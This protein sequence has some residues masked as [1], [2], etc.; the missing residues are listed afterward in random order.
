MAGLWTGIALLTALAVA[1]VLLPLLRARRLAQQELAE[2]RDR[3][4][5]DIFRERLAELEQE[6]S[7]GN[8]ADGDFA[9]LKLELERGLLED[10]GDQP[11][12][13]QTA[14]VSGGQW[15]T[16]V[17]LALLVPAIAFGLYWQL[18]SA[19][20]LQLALERQA[21][22]DPFDGRTPTLEEA[23]GRLE[24]ELE[25]NPENPEGWYLLATTYMG[26]GRYSDGVAAFARVLEQLP[27]D[28]PQYAGVMGQY[29][30]ALYFANEARMSE[31]VR[32][33]VEATLALD[34]WEVTSLGLLGID[35]F[36]SQR[37]A[38]AIG[39]WAKALQQADDAAAAG[40]LRAGIRRAQQELAALGQPVPEVPGLEAAEIRVA[41]RLGEGVGQ[42]LA[43]DQTVFVFARPVGGR[44]PLAAVRLQVSDLP[45]EVVLD[46]SLAMTPEAR[47]SSVD[48]VE[49]SA[50]ISLSGTPAAQSGDLYGTLS[51]V[52]VQ[53]Q[54]GVL[55]LVID[56]VVE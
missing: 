46:D 13:S 15:L 36:E 41:V 19:P 30:Q 43:P 31:R 17:L 51:P 24:Q 34:P 44:M 10:V 54:A 14:S 45:S 33:Q 53:G 25:A 49:V 6:R 37:Y 4:N 7:V 1:F 40:S 3:Q 22:P 39:H 28:A 50:R 20:K 38:E 35:A 29:A 48:E 11:R 9:E 56:Q 21:Q 55:E 16:G 52:A 23:V 32:S 18:G 12:R 2:E 5:I 8:L 26:V 27:K 42:D 47:L